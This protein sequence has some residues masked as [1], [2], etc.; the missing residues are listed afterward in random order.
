MNLNLNNRILERKMRSLHL[1]IKQH[2]RFA[3]KWPS[4]ASPD[5][6]SNGDWPISSLSLAGQSLKFISSLKLTKKQKF[7]LLPATFD[8]YHRLPRTMIARDASLLLLQSEP[9]ASE[10]RSSESGSEKQKKSDQLIKRNKF[11]GRGFLSTFWIVLFDLSWRC[12]ADTK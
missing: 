12:K 9:W 11:Q 8:A 2:T 6:A 3:P 5:E 1:W 4:P 7:F 10:E